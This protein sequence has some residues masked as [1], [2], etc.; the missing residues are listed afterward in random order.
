[1]ITKMDKELKNKL[2]EEGKSAKIFPSDFIVIPIL[3]VI[4]ILEEPSS[5]EQIKE[6][7]N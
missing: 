1:M 4:K 7:K 6:S 2:W 3:D 5:S